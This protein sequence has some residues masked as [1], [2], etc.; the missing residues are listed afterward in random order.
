MMLQFWPY[1]STMRR[2]SFIISKKTERIH[3]SK[4]LLLCGIACL[5]SDCKRSEH[6]A[7]EKVPSIANF[8]VD[9][10]NFRDDR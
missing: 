10:A 7:L 3:M 8:G 6:I 5:K 9:I 4:R 1:T 2:M